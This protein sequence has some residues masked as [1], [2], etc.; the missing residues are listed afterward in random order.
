MKQD[1]ILDVTRR[2]VEVPIEITERLLDKTEELLDPSSKASK[3]GSAI[4]NT[5]C[6]GLI[7]LGASQM[8]VGKSAWGLGNMTV[9]V[10]SIVSNRIYM[11][12]KTNK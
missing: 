1:R 12:W 10:I 6:T 3:I 11:N 5:V 4:S 7:L 8:F 2:A 9:G